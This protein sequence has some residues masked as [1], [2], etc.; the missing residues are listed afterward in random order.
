MEAKN[1]ERTHLRPPPPFSLFLLDSK[2]NSN[3]KS[4]MK[5]EEKRKTFPPSHEARENYGKKFFHLSQRTMM[6]YRASR[7]GTKA[8]E[9]AVGRE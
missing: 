4:E 8:A 3:S 2:N 7:M 1:D 5:K 9:M 6:M